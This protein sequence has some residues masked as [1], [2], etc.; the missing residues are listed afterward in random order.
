MWSQE[1]CLILKS[2][3]GLLILPHGEQHPHFT[4]GEIETEHGQL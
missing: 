3:V 1:L 4:D 2:K